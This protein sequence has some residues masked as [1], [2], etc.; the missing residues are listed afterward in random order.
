LGF[1]QPGKTGFNVLE[2]RSVLGLNTLDLHIKNERAKNAIAGREVIVGQAA[3]F[4][5]CGCAAIRIILLPAI[6]TDAP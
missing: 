4:L 6:E 3:D 5:Y 2:R 1:H